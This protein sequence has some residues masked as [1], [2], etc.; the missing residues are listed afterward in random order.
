MD[1]ESLRARL[2]GCY[3]TVPTP[4]RDEPDYPVDETALRSYVRFLIDNGL[5]ERYATFLAGGAAGD[6]STMTFEERRR[7]AAVVIDEVAGRAPVA[8]GA[9]TT[10]TLELVRLARTAQELGADFMCF[11]GHKMCGPT[12]VGALWARAELLEAMPPFLGGGEMILQVTKEGFTTNELPWKFEAGTPMVAEAVG[13][14]AAVD[15]LGAIGG[16][17]AV[18]RHE[19]ELTAYALRVLTEIGRAHV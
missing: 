2:E 10:S 5:S 12:G 17:E 9:Q 4:F 16:M 1:P 11:T 13:L 7:V 3:V 8:M 18:R 19:V 6:F 15:Y 14:G